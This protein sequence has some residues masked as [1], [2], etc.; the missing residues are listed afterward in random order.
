MYHYIT[1]HT[2][3][4]ETENKSYLPPRAIYRVFLWRFRRK[5][6]ISQQRIVYYREELL[7]YEAY[8]KDAQMSRA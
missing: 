7:Q 8:A 2:A 6:T 1:H 3:V 4:I 5:S